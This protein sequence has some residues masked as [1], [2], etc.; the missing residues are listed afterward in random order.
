[1]HSHLSA[2]V[3]QHLGPEH[4]AVQTRAMVGCD[5]QESLSLNITGNPE[6]SAAEAA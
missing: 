3:Q 2:A 5:L 6:V 1:M 4:W